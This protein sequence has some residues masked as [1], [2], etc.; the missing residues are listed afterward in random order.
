MVSTV[1]TLVVLTDLGCIERWVA[2][3]LKQVLI[4]VSIISS[5]D[6]IQ[7]LVMEV[8]GI[9][10]GHGVGPQLTQQ[11]LDTARNLH[12]LG[13][14]QQ[15]SL[16]LNR[17]GWKCASGC[18]S[19][20]TNVGRG[21]TVSCPVANIW[22]SVTCSHM[23]SEQSDN[24]ITLLRRAHEETPELESCMCLSNFS[25]QCLRTFPS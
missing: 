10:Q 8:K 18:R 23:S 19:I 22:M 9:Y 14:G 15:S 1:Q 12:H 7:L 17:C 5:K 13:Y 11:L 3:P 21:E 24:K 2:R 4:D 20:A 6:R 25:Q 16:K